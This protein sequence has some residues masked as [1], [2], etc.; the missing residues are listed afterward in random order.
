[1][2]GN[3]I[4][5]DTPENTALIERVV[6]RVIDRM[7]RGENHPKRELPVSKADFPKLLCLDQNKWIDLAKSHHGRAGGEPF[8]D[9]LAAIREA[10]A[11]QRLIV[12]VM[13]SNLIEV[14]EPADEGR[15][16]RLAEFMVELSGN[17]SMLNPKIVECV[18]LKHAILRQFSKQDP[19]AFPRH[20]LVRWGMAY[21]LGKEF[22]GDFLGQALEEP[23]ISVLAM[24]HAM[25]RESIAFGRGLDEQAAATARKARAA[26]LTEEQRRIAELYNLFLTTGATADALKEVVATIGV[27]GK[28]FFPWLAN[29]LVRF[30]E[31]VPDTWVINRLLLARDRSE[32][33][34]THRNDLK[35]FTFLKLAIPYGN[36]VVA[37]NLWAH[38]SRAEGLDGKYETTV[39][40]DLRDLR[41][42]LTNHGCL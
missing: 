25:D 6:E 14:S 26:A 22:D 3:S 29:N 35:D 41:A 27:D 17:C 16:Q 33:N 30:A 1:M 4:I 12:P 20:R 36:I 34:K 7:S 32:D 39:I 2:D 9:A 18:Q 21:A 37:E 40:S 28:V 38:L 5:P 15:R 13:P 42:E 11:K 10:V 19:G 31:H 24:V 23:E 8:A